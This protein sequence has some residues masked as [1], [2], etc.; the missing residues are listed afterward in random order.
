MG[1]RRAFFFMVVASTVCQAQVAEK[2]LPRTSER[3][4][5]VR[6]LAPAAGLVITRNRLLSTEDSGKSWFDRTPPVAGNAEILDVQFRDTQAGW[7]L[8]SAPERSIRLG[9]TT[10]GG[11]HCTVS[12]VKSL[13]KYEW[14]EISRIASLS[15]VDD[16]HGLG[17]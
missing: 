5:R 7:L 10:D 4:E 12:S 14:A 3:I 15:F 8:F 1:F 11:R 2:P 16:R 13:A 9:T 6:L 17:I